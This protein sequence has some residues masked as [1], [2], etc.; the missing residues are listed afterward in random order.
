M[1]EKG[2]RIGKPNDKGEIEDLSDAQLKQEASRLAEQIAKDC[3]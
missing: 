1:Y 2:G 3:K